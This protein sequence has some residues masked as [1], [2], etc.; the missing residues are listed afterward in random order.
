MTDETT[1]MPEAT[2]EVDPMA[3]PAPMPEAPIT[4]EAEPMAPEAPAEEA[5]ETPAE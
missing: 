5:P 3:A 2:P 1:N 4:P